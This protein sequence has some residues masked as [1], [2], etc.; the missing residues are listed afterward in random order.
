MPYCP[1][2]KYEY[3][4]GIKTCPDCDAQL[5]D[6]LSKPSSRDTELVVVGAYPFES[7]AQQAKLLLESNGI[8]TVLL[9]EIMSQTDIVLV[10]A[11]GGVKALVRKEDAER[12]KE[13]LAEL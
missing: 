3:R 6:E 8:E 7:I 12:A 11:D 5:V 2:C 9:N 4:S 10:F 13:I 1:K